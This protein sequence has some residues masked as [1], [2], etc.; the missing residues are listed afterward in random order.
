MKKR[1]SQGEKPGKQKIMKNTNCY[2][3]RNHFFLT[4]FISLSVYLH[5]HFLFPLYRSHKVG[6]HSMF[7]FLVSDHR[8]QI[9]LALLYIVGIESNFHILNLLLKH[10]FQY[11]NA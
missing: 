8:E 5:S 2:K 10:V 4:V 6:D 7:S 11:S 9:V 1:N 3:L